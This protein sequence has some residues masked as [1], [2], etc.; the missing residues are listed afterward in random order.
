[1]GT[2]ETVLGLVK[3]RYPKLKLGENDDYLHE[4]HLGKSL[5]GNDNLLFVV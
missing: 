2:V 3:R 5:S 4:A 1:M